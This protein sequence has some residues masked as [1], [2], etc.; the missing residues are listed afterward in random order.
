MTLTLT[1]KGFDGGAC[2]TNLLKKLIPFWAVRK[3]SFFY[4]QCSV[5]HSSGS[6]I[7]LLWRGLALDTLQEKTTMG[8][9]FVIRM[10][11]DHLPEDIHTTG[12]ERC[13]FSV[14]NPWTCLDRTHSGGVIQW[15]RIHPSPQKHTWTHCIVRIVQPTSGQPIPLAWTP[16]RA[17][18]SVKP[19]NTPK[20]PIPLD[21]ISMSLH[22]RIVQTFTSGQPTPL[23]SSDLELRRAHFSVSNPWTRLDHPCHWTSFQWTCIHPSPPSHT[24]THCST[25]CSSIY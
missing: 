22:V 9:L 6:A 3:W 7:Q 15:A 8:W 13:G 2:A 12:L 1:L 23:G 11:P 4:L 17:L 5:T 18:L 14:S 25:Y 20:P 19:L 10:A 24:L 16:P 21:V